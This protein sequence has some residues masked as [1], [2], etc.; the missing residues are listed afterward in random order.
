MPC[1]FWTGPRRGARHPVREPPLGPIY[2]P[3]RCAQVTAHQRIY[4][5][6]LACGLL[7]RDIPLLLIG[8]LGPLASVTLCDKVHQ[9]FFDGGEGAKKE[10]KCKKS[11]EYPKNQ[12]KS[13]AVI[14]MSPK[15]D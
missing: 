2:V 12:N 3:T 9:S 1:V 6:T 4:V 13:Y 11:L 15:Q 7:A 10:R 14:L 8:S 5:P